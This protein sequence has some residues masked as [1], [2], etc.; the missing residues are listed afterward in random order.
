MDGVSGVKG[1]EELVH[2]AQLLG[3]VTELGRARGG[4]GSDTI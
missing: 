4:L 3:K 2:I 1:Y